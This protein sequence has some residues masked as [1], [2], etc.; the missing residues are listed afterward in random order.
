MIDWAN[1]N[2]NSSFGYSGEFEG[3][4]HIVQLKKCVECE[5]NSKTIDKQMEL[6]SKNDKQLQD[7]RDKLK[8][9][10]KQ[11]KILEIKLEDALKSLRK[12]KQKEDND[13]EKAKITIKCRECKF[14]CGSEESL[15]EH[16]RE[17]KA[18]SRAEASVEKHQEEEGP[19]AEEESQCDKCSYK[20]KNRVLLSEHKEQVHTNRVCQFCGN[21]SPNEEGFKIHSR[22]H[23]TDLGEQSQQYYWK[24]KQLQ[25]HSL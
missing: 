24:Y 11:N 7:G 25:V 20:D 18:K 14:T 22:V 16:N 10:K 17:A 1:I 5:T 2:F 4:V 12:V 6:L 9:S 21:V 15:K 3:R 13:V 19:L 23:G 8:E